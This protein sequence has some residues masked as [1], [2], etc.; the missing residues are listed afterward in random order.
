M[1]TTDTKLV[2]TICDS[3]M[4]QCG[5]LVHV[6]DGK[7]VKIEGDP[8]HLAS[9]GF[10]CPMG[11]SSLQTVYH[12]DR[13]IYPLKRIGDRG[14]GQWKR[15]SW[16]E[17]LTDIAERILKV[18]EK[19]GPEAILYSFGTY[20]AKNG[21]ASFVGLLGALDSPGT[22]VP[23]CHYC[24]TPHIIGN[25]LTAGVIYDCEMGCPNFKDSKLEYM[26]FHNLKDV[27]SYLK[28]KLE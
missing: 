16:D 22:F 3:C 20:P 26:P 15:V 27:F 5:A 23:N 4:C 9:H 25:T 2:Q 1:K 12:P 14:E 19:Y 11:L 7:A 18:K 13:V 17:A 28:R 6:K 21:I 24:Y 8:E 10:M